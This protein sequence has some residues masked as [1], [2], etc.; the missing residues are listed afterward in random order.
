LQLIKISSNIEE[1]TQLKQKLTNDVPTPDITG[2]SF[3][4]SKSNTSHGRNIL[5]VANHLMGNSI[6]EDLD[7]N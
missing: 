3:E 7:E 2:E 5:I 1:L 4:I 6:L